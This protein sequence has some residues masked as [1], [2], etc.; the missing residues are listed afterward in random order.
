[1]SITD[2]NR[3]ALELTR[4]RDEARAEV[5]RLRAELAGAQ[6]RADGAESMRK[7]VEGHALDTESKLA[8][9][10]AL[11]TEAPHAPGVRGQEWE[12]RRDAHFAGAPAA[13]PN[14]GSC[15][16]CGSVPVR[17]MQLCNTCADVTETDRENQRAEARTA[18]EQ[19][20]LDA[21]RGAVIAQHGGQ[22]TIGVDSQRECG[23]AELA[24]RE[25][26]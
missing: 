1:M 11:L 18:A 24:R 13:A 9:A 5:E 16:V 26:K 20:V 23:L 7:A 17:H 19:R 21:M 10:N 6:R 2:W 4:E 15:D 25:G 3:M 14:D 12:R 22:L 8:T